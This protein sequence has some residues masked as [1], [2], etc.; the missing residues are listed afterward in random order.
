MGPGGLFPTHP[1]LA[2]ILGETDF[3]FKNFYFWIWLDPN[4]SDFQVPDLRNLA[5]AGVVCTIY[6]WCMAQGITVS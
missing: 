5:W 1:D 2:D 3:D 4:F 6:A